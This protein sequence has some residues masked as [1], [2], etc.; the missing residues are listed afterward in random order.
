MEG[1]AKSEEMDL[2]GNK[3][4]QVMADFDN[5]S[6]EWKKGNWYEAVPPL[7]RRIRGLTLVDY[8]GK[9]HGRKLA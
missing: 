6:R 9:N 5:P 4:F 3:R 1:G 7:T 2:V 8:F